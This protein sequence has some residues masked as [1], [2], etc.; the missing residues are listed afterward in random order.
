MIGNS[1]IMELI[2][3]GVL[4]HYESYDHKA[5]VEEMKQRKVQGKSMGYQTNNLFEFENSCYGIPDLVK[6]KFFEWKIGKLRSM[7]FDP[8]GM[9]ARMYV[10]RSNKYCKRFFPQEVGVNIK[11]I[12][13]LNDDK[14]GLIQAGLAIDESSLNL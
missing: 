10:G 12:I 13:N 4:W 1:V 11:P 8:D 9:I 3:N 5:A 14:F 6:Q 2:A 7:R